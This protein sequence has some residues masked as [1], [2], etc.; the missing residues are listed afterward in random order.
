VAVTAGTPIDNYTLQAFS[1]LAF[2][3]GAF[4]PWTVGRPISV[5]VDIKGGI[6]PYVLTVLEPF[7]KP[8]G[9]ILDGVNL[10]VG[11]IPTG[12]QA[13]PIPAGGS[14]TYGFILSAQDAATPS[15]TA[16]GPIN[17]TVNDT[18][19]SHIGDFLAVPYNKAL[20]RPAPYAGG[21]APYT[22]T[23]DEG[24]MPHGVSFAP[25]ELTLVGTADVPGSYPVQITAKD[26][27]LSAATSQ[28]TGVCCTP[29]GST[30][31]L[32]LGA[33]A[34]GFYLDAVQGS[35][36]TIAV[37]TAPKQAKRLLR[38]AVLDTDGTTI[39]D[40]N[41][42][43]GKGKA[44]VKFVAPSSGRFFFVLASDTGDASSLVGVGKVTAT[45]SGAGQDP[46]INFVAG[47][48]YA[49][50]F[51]ALAGAKITFVG[52]PDRSGLALRALYMLDPN[53]NIV[54]IAPTEVTERNGTVTVKKT[55]PTSDTENLSGTWKLVI[56]ALPGPQGH[57]TYSYRVTEPKGG[58]YSFD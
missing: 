29:L 47:K 3:S 53:G 50:K 5:P 32:A 44:G 30:T 45:K 10:L 52:K 23:V 34:C 13:A 43:G 12:P 11:G 54:T 21:T 57:F 58:A 25:G 18:L 28:S 4:Q 38:A 49:V 19:K 14:Y 41:A 22:A 36:V 16:S 46:D 31:P 51:G 1:Q 15:N 55:L 40:T 6:P 2:K 20:N 24:L 33:G 17:F 42:K 27:A 26:I 39:L 9:L 8:D 35:T 56:G 48:Q 37:K 7:K